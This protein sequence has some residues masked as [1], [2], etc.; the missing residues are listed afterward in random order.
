MEP[1]VLVPG[2]VM[3]A[4]ISYGP[5]LEVLEDEARV[6]PKD[7]EV[8]TTDAP[9]PNYRL[10]LE[11]DGIN[12]AADAAGMNRFHLVGYSGGGACS[13]VFITRHPERVLRV[14]P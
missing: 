6:V 11:V 1:V 2:G 7:L 8:Y 13:L 4:A 9:P 10:D 3:P 12:C 14:S 5:L